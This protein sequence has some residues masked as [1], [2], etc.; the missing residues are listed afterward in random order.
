MRRLLNPDLMNKTDIKKKQKMKIQETTNVFIEDD[1][2]SSIQ[3]NS[4]YTPS[5]SSGKLSESESEYI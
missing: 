5:W 4:I 1:Y 2:T 3:S